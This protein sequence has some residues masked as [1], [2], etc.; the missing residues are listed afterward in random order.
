M[1]STISYIVIGILIVLSVVVYNFKKKQI[2]LY[3]LSVQRYP[4]IILQ[5]K[6]KKLRGEIESI[7]LNVKAIIMIDIDDPK[8]ELITSNREFNY[9]PLSQL[10]AK[11]SKPTSIDKNS[12]VDFEIPFT[13]FKTLLKDGVHPFRTFRFII[14]SKSG[15]S[16]KS[17]EMGFNKKWIIYR[18]DSG[19]YN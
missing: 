9:Y 15:K 11:Y 3:Q 14:Y 18:P 8:V 2:R 19:N 10:I 4:E 13:D 12:T 5:V 1:E 7:I 16:Y 6:I 17:H